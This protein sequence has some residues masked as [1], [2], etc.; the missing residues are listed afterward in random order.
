M[1]SKHPKVMNDFASQMGARHVTCQS[2]SLPI[3]THLRVIQIE[4]Q[5]LLTL[6]S[7]PSLN[8]RQNLNQTSETPNGSFL[9]IPTRS[10]C[11][12]NTCTCT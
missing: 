5:N 8:R 12:V 2:I 7:F 9:T 4:S 1:P 3:E 10:D 11:T 6:G